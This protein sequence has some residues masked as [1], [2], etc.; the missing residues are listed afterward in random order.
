MVVNC[1]IRWWVLISNIAFSGWYWILV[2]SISTSKCNE[3][4]IKYLL[5]AGLIIYWVTMWMLSFFMMDI[6]EYRASFIAMPPNVGM[7]F[8]NIHHKKWRYS[9]NTVYQHAPFSKWS[10][11]F[12]LSNSKVMKFFINFWGFLRIYELYPACAQVF[13]RW[14]LF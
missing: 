12:S 9:L 7:I 4:F 5:L 1:P 13:Y 3:M 11:N 8:T 10:G 6:G 14:K 2:L